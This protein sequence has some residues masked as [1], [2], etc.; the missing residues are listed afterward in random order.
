MVEFLGSFISFA[1]KETLTLPFQ[2][3]YPLSPSIVLLL[4]LRH[5]VLY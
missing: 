2:F 1:N 4:Y 5:Q 3:V